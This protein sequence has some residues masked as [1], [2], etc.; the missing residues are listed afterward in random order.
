MRYQSVLLVLLFGLTACAPD[1]NPDRSVTA[2]QAELLSLDYQS[3]EGSI[4]FFFETELRNTTDSTLT[5]FA[6][7]HGVDD[8]TQPPLRSVYPPRAQQAMP[9]DGRFAVARIDLGI[10]MVAAPG[11]TV[12]FQG[13]LPVP[14]YWVTGEPIETDRF[15]TLTLYAYAPDGRN[16]LRR[17]FVLVP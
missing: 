4:T 1:P 9:L 3:N 15:Q 17:P 14:R 7:A 2:L 12:R 5:F 10:E 8:L 11:E 16:I 13:A 6:F